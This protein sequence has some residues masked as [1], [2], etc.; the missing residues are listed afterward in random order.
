MF[1]IKCLNLCPIADIFAANF[2][3][4]WRGP[5][6]SFFGMF[7]IFFPSATGI[8]AG[9]NISGDLKASWA[10]SLSDVSSNKIF[11]FVGTQASKSSFFCLLFSNTPPPIGSKCCYTPWYIVGHFLDYCVISHYLSYYWWV[12]EM[13]NKSTIMSV[14]YYFIPFYA[15][16]LVFYVCLVKIVK[17]YQICKWGP[18][19]HTFTTVLFPCC[20]L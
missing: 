7:S 2:V 20:F 19:Y 1:L 3:P 16:L 15:F 17:L 5:E 11:L 10:P 13:P 14:D 12:S 9:A 18:L 6:G 8:L 4:G